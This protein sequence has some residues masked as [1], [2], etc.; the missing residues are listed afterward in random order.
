MS[1]DKKDLQYVAS[2]ARL[3][4]DDSEIDSLTGQMNEIISFV[5]KINSLDTS[6]CSPSA[7][8]LDISN[9]MRDDVVKQSSIETIEKILEN[10]PHRQDTF[11]AVPRILE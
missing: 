9:Q 10:A 2:L 8:V 11:I 6:S 4:L 7:H 3:E 1:V 5:E